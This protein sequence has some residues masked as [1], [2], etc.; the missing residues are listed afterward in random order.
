MNELENV[1]NAFDTLLESCKRLLDNSQHLRKMLRNLRDQSRMIFYKQVQISSLID[2]VA[3]F[4]GFCIRDK[5][6]EDMHEACLAQAAS[7]FTVDTWANII[8]DCK[9]TLS[10]LKTEAQAFYRQRESTIGKE[11]AIMPQEQRQA[12]QKEI[13]QNTTCILQL[14]RGANYL[15]EQLNKK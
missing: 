15:Q 10:N 14:T 2:E 9:N 13:T 5:V 1:S 11:D 8:K 12:I 3:V 4:K 6:A 7:E